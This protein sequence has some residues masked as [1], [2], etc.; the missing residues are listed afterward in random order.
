MGTLLKMALGAVG[1][2]G[3]GIPTGWL[4]AGAV[5]A[6]MAVLGGTWTAG[7]NYRGTLDE[8]ARLQ[9]ENQRLHE[10]AAETMRQMDSVNRI[11]QA[12]TDKAVAAEKRARELQQQID[13]TPANNS[14]CGD[15]GTA[16]RLFNG[17]KRVVPAV[18]YPKYPG[19]PGRR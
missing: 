15:V 7:Y 8:S 14:D 12:D 4:I 10:A 17:T 19:S 9:L 5:M 1:L 11:Q 6:V 18:R 3:G 2:A 16:D 13:D